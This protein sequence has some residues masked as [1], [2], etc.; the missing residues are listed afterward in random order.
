[1]RK[2]CRID[3]AHTANEVIEESGS[4]LLMHT[5]SDELCDPGEAMGE[6]RIIQMVG[7]LSKRSRG[8]ER[9]DHLRC[10]K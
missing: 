4:A 10:V 1:M 2:S 9:Q 8:Q 7:S 3:Y 5:V 6:T